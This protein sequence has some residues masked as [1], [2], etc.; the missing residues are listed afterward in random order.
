M[1][2]SIPREAQVMHLTKIYPW[3]LGI[4]VANARALTRG[5]FLNLLDASSQNLQIMCRNSASPSAEDGRVKA[6]QIIDGDLR[7][8]GSQLVV[9]SAKHLARSLLQL[10]QMD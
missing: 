4:G 1:E 5:V 2:T 3:D 8:K 9:C 7:S 6:A 10:L